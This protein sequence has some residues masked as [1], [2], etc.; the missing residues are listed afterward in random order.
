MELKNG[1]FARRVALASALLTLM[2]CNVAYAVS[3]PCDSSLDASVVITTPDRSE[4]HFLS[5]QIEVPH[6]E[7]G[8]ACVTLSA[9]A[10]YGPGTLSVD[11]GCDVAIQWSCGEDELSELPAGERAEV[12]LVGSQEFGEFSRDCS[13]EVLD[14]A[15]QLEI[16][17]RL[18]DVRPV[19]TDNEPSNNTSDDDGCSVTSLHTPSP[20]A[21]PVGLL[22]LGVC[23]M[24]RRRRAHPSKSPR[25]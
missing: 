11:N 15:I 3:E 17:G 16:E 13:L 14:T 20:T 9:G 4:E 10:C 22:L 6:D 8:A 25:T 19:P 5:G 24:A 18:D 23:L 21:L 1:K 7:T 12:E 2:A